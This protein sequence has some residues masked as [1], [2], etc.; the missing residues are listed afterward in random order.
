MKNLIMPYK[1]KEEKQMKIVNKQKTSD[2]VI[3]RAKSSPVGVD[4]QMIRLMK[5]SARN[6]KKVN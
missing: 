1:G 4:W 6:R 5:E 2:K 3:S